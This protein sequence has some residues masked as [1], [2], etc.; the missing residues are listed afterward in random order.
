[1]RYTSKTE[2]SAESR[3]FN[4]LVDVLLS[5]WLLH[6]LPGAEWSI[7]WGVEVSWSHSEGSFQ[8]SPFFHFTELKLNQTLQWGLSVARARWWCDRKREQHW[9]WC[10]RRDHRSFGTSFELRFV[11]VNIIIYWRSKQRIKRIQK[12]TVK[13]SN[14]SQTLTQL[15][16]AILNYR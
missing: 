11:M 3:S 16:N 1:M 15:I 9:C 5:N 4:I 2:S 7:S 10:F 12:T 8:G 13:Q 6:D 14:N